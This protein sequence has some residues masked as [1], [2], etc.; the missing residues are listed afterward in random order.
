[1]SG[2]GLAQ[3]DGVVGLPPSKP[4]LI[5]RGVVRAVARAPWAVA[6]ACPCAAVAS[7]AGEFE[8]EYIFMRLSYKPGM[9]SKSG[10]ICI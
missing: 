2:I 8:I 6:H 5:M 3:K 4:L 7:G 1:M 9:S 10:P